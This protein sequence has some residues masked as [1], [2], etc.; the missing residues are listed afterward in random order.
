MLDTAYY[1]RN[2][3][4]N[5]NEVTSVRM[6]IIKKS[7]NNNCWTGSGEKG[8]HLLCLQESK[9]IQPLWRTIWR[10]LQKPGINCHMTKQTHHWAYT[11]RKPEL[12]RTHA[13]QCA[14][15]HYLQQLG[16]GSNLYI[17]T[18]RQ[19]D[20]VVVHTR[21][22]ILLSYKRNT[23][24]SVPVRWMNLEPIIQSEIKSERERQTSPI[25]GI[26]EDG[27]DDPTCR[28]AKETQT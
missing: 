13:P 5:H 8:T 15:Q 11:L 12:K 3:N 6:A 22:R 20:K 10:F 2:A 28:A 25:Y 17:S 21:N 16:H 14:L 18:S 27:T 1:Q 9:L 4:Q 26:Q 19:M 23:S 7:A 24:E